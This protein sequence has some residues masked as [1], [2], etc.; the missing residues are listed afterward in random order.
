MSAAVKRK[1]PPAALGF[2]LRHQ[3][4]ICDICGTRYHRRN[5]T[6]SWT[7]Q[8]PGHRDGWVKTIINVC[9]K[10]S[11]ESISRRVLMV[12]NVIKSE[13]RKR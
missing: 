2:K 4:H 6:E 8:N 1:P 12:A 3:P 13:W 10:C 7:T 11:P 5:K 9:T